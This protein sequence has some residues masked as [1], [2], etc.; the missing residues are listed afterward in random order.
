MG[1]KMKKKI[2]ILGFIIAFIVVLVLVS[3]FIN[4]K[5]IEYLKNDTKSQLD[6]N[7]VSEE[8]EEEEITIEE[9]NTE[10]TLKP[11]KEETNPEKN[12]VEEKVEE[13]KIEEA[14]IEENSEEI[15]EHIEPEKNEESFVGVVEVSESDFETEVLNSNKKVLVDFYTTWCGPCQ[16]LSPIVEDVANEIDDVKFVKVDIDR[17]PNL[18]DEYAI[19]YIPT[20]VVIENGVVKNTST[21]L[22]TK[23]RVIDLLN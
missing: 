3:S 7:T 10:E 17:A 12:L 19:M 13:T 22:I 4:E 15:I 11:I 6:K 23:E 21:G 18:A 9:I 8:V 2:I 20:L 5:G 1:E 14:K 16:V